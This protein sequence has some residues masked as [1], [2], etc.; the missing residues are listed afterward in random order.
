LNES[1]WTCGRVSTVH[2]VRIGQS[3]WMD[4]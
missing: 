4:S 1:F 2:L 3:T